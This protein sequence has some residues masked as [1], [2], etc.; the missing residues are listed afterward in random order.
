LTCFSASTAAPLGKFM[1]TNVRTFSI[2]N[3]KIKCTQ[4][5][6]WNNKV[7]ITKKLSLKLQYTW[8]LWKWVEFFFFLF[9]H[10][11]NKKI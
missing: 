6:N 9:T 1:L 8:K 10:G 7:F 3:L 4:I 2:I 11:L 5:F